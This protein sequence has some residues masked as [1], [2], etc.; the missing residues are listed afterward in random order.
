MLRGNFFDEADEARGVPLPRHRRD[1]VALWV[2]DDQG[3][4]GAC[5]VG[6]PGFEVGVIEHDVFDL[7][8]F[9]CPVDG[10]DFAFKLKLG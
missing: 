2:D 4:P 9:D 10:F 7:V 1:D 5:G 3:G 8:A 6:L